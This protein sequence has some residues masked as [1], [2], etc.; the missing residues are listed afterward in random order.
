MVMV[1]HK[2]KQVPKL[3]DKKEN[4]CGCS[5]CFA[6]C[7]VGAIQM[8]ADQEGFLYPTVN[9]EQCVRC[10][11]CLKVCSFKQMQKSKGFY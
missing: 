1:S 2:D 4:C 3:Y 8:E 11:Q 9:A 6:V 7:P 5:A 10:Y